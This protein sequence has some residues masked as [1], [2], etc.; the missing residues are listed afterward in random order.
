M[1]LRRLLPG[2]LVILV[3]L[4]GYMLVAVGA[5]FTCQAFAGVPDDVDLGISFDEQ[6]GGGGLVGETVRLL[7]G[8]TFVSR[9]DLSFVSP[10]SLGLSFSAHYNSRSPVA[11]SL[12]F[13]WSHPYSVLLEPA[14]DF[15]SRTYIRIVDATG[16]GHYFRKKSPELFRGV[17][18]ER[19]HVTAETDVFTWH[20]LNGSRF[21]FSR[22]GRLLWIDDEKGNRLELGYD[23]QNRLKAVTDSASG[24]VLTFNYNENDLI[25]SIAGPATEAVANGIW[26]VFGYDANQ[27]L[28]SVS[29]K[30]GTGFDNTY[31]DSEDVH[32]LT[33]VYNR[34]GQLI[35]TWSYDD[36]DRC[37]E[38]FNPNGRSVSVNYVSN[39]RV[40]VTDAYHVERAYTVRKIG[41]RKRITAMQGLADPPYTDT[42]VIRWRYDEKMRLVRVRH[43]NGSVNR[44]RNFD[45]RGNPRTIILAAGTEQRRKIFFTYHS[46]MNVVLSRSE[47]SVLGAGRKVTIFDFDD[48]GNSAPN[49]SPTGLIYR[50]IEQGYT[51]NLAGGIVPYEYI[52]RLSYNDRGQVLTVDGP[53]TGNDDTTE[54]TY[55]N[56]TG[57]PNTIARPLIGPTTF[58]DYDTAGQ[59]GKVIDVN[60]QSIRFSYDGRGRVTTTFYDA[61]Q[62]TA[63]LS[64]NTAGL[65]DTTT[66]EDDVYKN[67]EYYTDYARLYR[68]YDFDN[69]YI[70]H[71]YDSRGNLIERSRH[72]PAEER[73]SRNRWS[74]DSPDVP[75]KLHKVINFDE[76]FTE[77][78]YDSAGNLA[79]MTDP[80]LNTT[81]YQYDAFNRL[82][83]V[84]QTIDNPGDVVTSYDYDTHGNLRSVTDAEHHQTIY[85]YDDMGRVV[86]TLSPDIG[87]TKYSY[88]EA[89]NLVSKID[90]NGIITTYGYDTLNRLTSVSFADSAQNII[91][92]YDEG[93]FGIGQ[94]TGMIDLSGSTTFGYNNRGRMVSKISTINN[95]AYQLSRYYTPGGRLSTITYPSGRSIDY[96]RYDSGK[97][98]NVATTLNNQ[99]AM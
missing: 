69:N 33:E 5:P 85:E 6:Q 59:P 31:S 74:Y 95:I 47:K 54:F 13:G 37:I 70:H 60:N 84:I 73:Y 40:K 34:A 14:F 44:Y 55:F 25:E 63:G 77:Y 27:N 35:N 79:S 12:G 15:N 89:G 4:S 20:R 51:R 66:D 10:H 71:N 50:I 30:D 18:R 1:P 2:L 32:N 75:G 29:Y 46:D 45:R 76:S 11:S 16:R 56:T 43:A 97:I 19:S 3:V 93:P 21:G 42:T 61:D 8:N 68:I 36:Q 65:V 88:D 92:S 58:L 81:E 83:D 38:N 26:V 48:D 7:N 39:H 62:S 52:T 17:F 28:T 78:R 9:T 96:T 98:K 57:D 24:R 99:T 49:E 67:F 91:Y 94:R 90:A 22:T 86:T 23:R 72:D 41:R 64:Y 87:T 53:L 80:E 82:T